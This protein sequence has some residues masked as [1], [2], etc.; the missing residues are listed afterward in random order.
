MGKS[1]EQRMME[2][3]C[4]ITIDGVTMSVAAY[5]KQ[6]KAEK[7]KAER[8]KKI[9]E[10][11]ARIMP[12]IPNLIKGMMSKTK[13]L[14]SLKAWQ[15]NGARQWGTI[16][17]EIINNPHIQPPFATY[18]RMYN[19]L[20]PIIKKIDEIA[21]NSK[22]KDIYGFIEKLAYKLDDMVEQLDKL[23]D[24]ITASGVLADNNLKAKEVINGEGKRLGLRILTQ[25]IWA[26][27]TE[28]K[29]NV[30]DLLKLRDNTEDALDANENRTIRL[31]TSH[32]Y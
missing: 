5:N 28:M 4:M 15:K 7:A 32:T 30:A 14:D 13:L 19:E 23:S 17:R 1:F 2:E 6:R 24:G 3:S 31:T 21:K 29:S 12:H 20:Q 25:R 18:C 9:R 16:H 8:I 22:D 26:C 10:R 11:N 27:M